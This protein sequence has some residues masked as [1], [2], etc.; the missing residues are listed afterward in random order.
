MATQIK[1]RKKTRKTAERM[2]KDLVCGADVDRDKSLKSVSAGT[3]YF[4]CSEECRSKFE[5]DPS[6]YPRA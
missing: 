1:H 4:F 3:E 6:D 2:A 5:A